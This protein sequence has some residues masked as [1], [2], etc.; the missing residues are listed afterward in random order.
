MCVCTVFY[1]IILFT[2]LQMTDYSNQH[3]YLTICLQFPMAS[4]SQI[5]GLLGT[6]ILRHICKYK[7]YQC[8][9]LL[10]ILSPAPSGSLWGQLL[11]LF[12]VSLPLND[13]L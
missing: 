7:N 3:Y 6:D 11:P 8:S 12:L 4:A 9:N 5:G 1:Q 10:I 2:C 13:Y